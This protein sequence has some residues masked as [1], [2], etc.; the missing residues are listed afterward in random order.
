MWQGNVSHAGEKTRKTHVYLQHTLREA[1]QR[2][3]ERSAKGAV[4]Q[5]EN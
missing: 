3:H 4:L 5:K 1:M 2:L